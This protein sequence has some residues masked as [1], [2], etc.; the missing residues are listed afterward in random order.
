LSVFARINN[1][2]FNEEKKLFIFF[3]LQSPS[4]YLTFNVTRISFST[5]L[6]MTSNEETGEKKFT[7]RIVDRKKQAILDILQVV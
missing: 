6:T 1:K 4:P 3:K 5:I 2:V 7:G